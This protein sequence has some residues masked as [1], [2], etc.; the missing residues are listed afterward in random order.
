MKKIILLFQIAL[1]PLIAQSTQ[2]KRSVLGSASVNAQ[3]SSYKLHGTL[4]QVA[5]DLSSSVLLESTNNLVIISSGY[6]GWIVR[7]TKLDVEN[8]STIPTVFKINPA[9]PNPFNPTTRI[10]MEIPD[11]GQVQIT[12]YDV[13]GRI[14]M[15]HKHNYPSAGMYSFQWNPRNATG[16]P[17]ATGTYILMVTHQNKIKTQKITYLK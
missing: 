12:I 13:L 8:E 10:D 6:W 7:W 2:I 16:E 17:L 15:E 3:S 4:G 1:L 9:Y 5:I 11:V 14:V